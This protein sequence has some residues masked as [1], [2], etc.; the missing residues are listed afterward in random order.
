MRKLWSYVK[1]IYRKMFYYRQHKSVTYEYPY[2]NKHIH[3]FSRLE[4]KNDFNECTACQICEDVC[5]VGS[6]KIVGE[7]FSKQ[8]K[9][10]QTGKGFDQLMEI[11]NFYV[12]YATCI[13]C[14]LCIREC[15]T[16][17]LSHEKSFVRAEPEVRL[18]KKDLKEGIQTSFRGVFK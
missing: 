12:D 13:Q 9:K 2:S 7:Q 10:P 15:P 14:G 17:S 6:I 11:Q 16:E 4:I 8:I 3:I 18:L 5:P 1:F